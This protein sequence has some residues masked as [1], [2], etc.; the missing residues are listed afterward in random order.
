VEV[1]VK[2]DA[3]TKDDKE[4]Y[5]QECWK[6]GKPFL[7]TACRI[8]KKMV[9]DYGFKRDYVEGSE[10][11]SIEKPRTDDALKRFVTS[12]EADGVQIKIAPYVDANEFGWKP[13]SDFVLGL[14][15]LTQAAKMADRI[16]AQHH[17]HLLAA[18]IGYFKLDKTAPEMNNGGRKF[19]FVRRVSGNLQ[20]FSNFNF[21]ICFYGDAWD[22]MDKEQRR[23]VVDH[24]LCHCKMEDGEWTL[25]EHDIED[26]HAIVDRHGTILSGVVARLDE[27]QEEE[28]TDA[29]SN[30]RKGV[31]KRDKGR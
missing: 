24:E 20:Y 16:I 25:I 18:N 11:F 15:P 2:E 30:K 1:I 9:K 19:A 31:P 29:D 3:K 17:K 10:F 5:F 6:K 27:I 12:L 13:K 8:S 28:K 23:A 14:L 7:L 22:V 4:L 26:F 21:L